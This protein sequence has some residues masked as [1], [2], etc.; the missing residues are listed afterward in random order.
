MR[1]LLRVSLAALAAAVIAALAP[2]VALAAPAGDDFDAATEITAL[3]FTGAL[4]TTGATKAPDDP[5]VCGRVGESTLW[6]RH[7]A[8]ADGIV[9]LRLL[10]DRKYVSFAVLTGQR[11]ALTE[12]PGSCASSSPESTFH[13][14]AGTTYYV[15]VRE[16]ASW[17]SG[18]LTLSLRK[19]TP[20]PND[21]RASA[22]VTTLPAT[23][24]GDLRLAGAEPGEVPP[25]CNT[26]ATQSVWYRY[27]ATRTRYVSAG[28]SYG[29]V[30]VH[31]ATDLSELDCFAGV[32]DA[33]FA[34]TAGENYLIRV[35]DSLQNARD[36]E[37]KI[38][39]AS[40]LAPQIT[41]DAGRYGLPAAGDEVRFSVYAGDSHRRKLVSGTLSFGDGT[42][43]PVQGEYYSH[44]YQRDGDYVVTVS[45][46]TA[47]GR[48][49]T[50]T[51][52][53]R[54]ETHDVAITGL[55]APAGFTPGETKQIEV[56]ATSRVRT[57]EVKVWF[58]RVNPAGGND[59]LMGSL[60]QQVSPGVTTEFPFA[61]TYTGKDAT[62]GQVTFR[63]V[64]AHTVIGTKDAK[65]EDNEARATSVLRPAQT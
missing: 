14:T 34:A 46:A 18:P 10:S 65:P 56:A 26:Q 3:P 40:P 44:R 61:Y 4:D 52:T 8:P 50:A 60:T 59:E 16:S 35:A 53:V 33:V 29:T 63:A 48:T 15:V 12:V 32:G 51:T 23:H 43:V 21:N 47:D 17:E 38:G 5:Y 39:A 6:L 2:G 58:Y 27:T 49:G 62:D 55:T 42:S 20:E 31:R 1:K 11:G 24:T 30:S 9:R 22:K 36:F 37:L 25:S 28:S 64:V 54:V 57:E 41:W 19:L 13:V 7:T 45:G